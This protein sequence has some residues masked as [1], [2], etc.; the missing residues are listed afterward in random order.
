MA[1]TPTEWETG[2][3]ITA[4]LL[5]HAEQGI[6]DAYEIVTLTPTYGTPEYDGSYG[7][8]PVS[9]AEDIDTFHIYKVDLS[10]APELTEDWE[11]GAA[12]GLYAYIEVVGVGNFLS[13]IA[14]SDYQINNSDGWSI[15]IYTLS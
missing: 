14:Y 4:D 6:A 5:N 13:C 10:N 3:I 11:Y 2:D 1:Y 9:F 7:S 15:P 12:T 8:V